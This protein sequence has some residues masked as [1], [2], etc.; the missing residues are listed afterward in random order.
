MATE[1][2]ETMAEDISNGT[3]PLALESITRPR[4]GSPYLELNES[5]SLAN[6]DIEQTL[7]ALLPRGEG[8]HGRVK[9][10]MRYAVFAG[11]KRLRPFLTLQSAR[12]FGVPTSRALR[13]ASAIEF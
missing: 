13:A 11:G 4:Q 6:A 2:Q 12:L 5:W 1:E 8:L 7:D 3:R 9:E 10:A